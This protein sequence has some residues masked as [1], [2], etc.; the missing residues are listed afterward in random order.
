MKRQLVIQIQNVSTPRS[1]LAVESLLHCIASV[2]A[3]S[4]WFI[5]EN[6]GEGWLNIHLSCVNPP[7][8]WRAIKELI[9]TEGQVFRSLSRHWLVVCEG[10][11]SWANYVTLENSFS[12]PD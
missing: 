1:T 2:A 11:K 12:N 9:A 5:D 10:N 6:P 7:R 4:S 3:S 8:L